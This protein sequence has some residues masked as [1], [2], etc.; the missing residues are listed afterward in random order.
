MR[1][2]HPCIHRRDVTTHAGHALRKQKGGAHSKNLR[3]EKD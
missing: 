3:V 1:T 2:V